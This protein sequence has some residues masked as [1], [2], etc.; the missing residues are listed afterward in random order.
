M[1]LVW[2]KNNDEKEFIES[3][4]GRNSYM[5]FLE[6]FSLEIPFISAYDFEKKQMRYIDSNNKIK[7][8]KE[9]KTIKPNKEEVILD[10]W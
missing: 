2:K 4:Y 3:I 7:T 5:D 9:F 8:F 6:L 10:D 1:K